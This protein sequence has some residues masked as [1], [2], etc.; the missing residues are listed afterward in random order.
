MAEI[1]VAKAEQGQTKIKNVPIAVTPE[2]FWCCPSPVAFQK[3]LK[4]QNPQNRS[5]PSSPP[6]PPKP[7]LPK[8]RKPSSASV[9]TVIASDDHR[10]HSGS[11]TATTIAAPAAQDR[12]H[13]Q[14]VE[15]LPRKVAIEFGEPG[16]SDMKVVLLG[17]QGFCVKLSVHKKVL[18]DNSSF[19]VNK[20]A[21]KDSGF[22][23]IEIDSC[24]DVEIYVETVG[25]MYCKDMK[26]RL[27]KQSVS[28]VLRFLKVAELL[29]FN[30]CI[31]SCLD[32]LEAVPWVGEEEE[33][34]VISSILELKHEGIGVRVPPV[35]KRVTS[36]TV[37]PPKETLSQIIE[38]VLRSNEE[39]GRH[40]MK[41]VV[42]KLL[43][44]QNSAN[45]ADNFNETIYSSCQNCLDTVLSLFRQAAEVEPRTESASK[46][47]AIESDNLS[48]LLD[49]LA[50][51]RAA[52]EFAVR[53]A[54]Q[55]ELASLHENLPLMTRFHI[56]RVSSRLFI[57][58]GRGE[59]LPSKETRLELL[60]RWLQPLINDYNWLQHGCRSF[61]GKLVEEG[62]GRTILTLPLED[63]QS[64]L[65]SWM[66]SF[67]TT[68]DGC[69][70]L[71][72]AFEVWWR[73]SFI[74][75][76]ATVTDP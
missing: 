46:Q 36:D 45:S 29:G 20:L 15:T 47:I 2:G 24:E 16:T 72:R 35:L 12:P 69:P 59:V 58:I 22:S 3:T 25:L 9:R 32:Y 73:R 57:G 11:D 56:S 43:R 51:R 68:G 50:E 62:I 48:W 37:D 49:M 55:K 18:V 42:L 14:K 33:E 1:R 23:C 7:H 30:S 31:Q 53:W 67:L 65:L 38:L 74:R 13:R 26:N 6:P 27:M 41:A 39:K 8:H 71:Q 28:R 64:I 70:N 52:E 34:R 17:K 19:F 60:R 10:Q 21:D 4:S 61:D 76:Y 63:Q 54:S 5:K 66:A 44:E 75:P 40:E